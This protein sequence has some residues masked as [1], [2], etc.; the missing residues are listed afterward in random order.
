MAPLKL[1]NSWLVTKAM[2]GMDKNISILIICGLCSNLF[3]C[4]KHMMLSFIFKCFI[5]SFIS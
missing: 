1:T 5:K 3:E 2:Q 4:K